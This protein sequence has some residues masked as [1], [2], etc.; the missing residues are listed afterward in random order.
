MTRK[1]IQWLKNTAV[2]C[3]A[4]TFVWLP[5]TK[6]NYPFRNLEH[7]K[8]V[9]FHIYINVSQLNFTNKLFS[10]WVKY[11]PNGCQGN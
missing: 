2:R 10:D 3:K 11:I 8:N 5:H 4:T 6:Q 1:R 7:Y 9:N